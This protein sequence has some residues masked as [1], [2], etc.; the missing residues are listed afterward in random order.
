[1]AELSKTPEEIK[2]GLECAVDKKCIGKECPYFNEEY[3]CIS[4]A[5]VDALALIQQLEADLKQEKADHQHTYECA[6]VFQ[7]ENAELLEKVKQ[8]E[9]ERDAL[10]NI[11]KGY[12]EC[13]FCKHGCPPEKEEHLFDL[14]YG[15]DI[16]NCRC[17]NCTTKNNCWEWRG[18]CKENGGSDA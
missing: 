11:M 5:Q 17:R 2:K 12:R 6:E 1:M 9:R 14:C 18:P 16:E 10:L 15:C 4:T 13:D 3:S 7:K 8:L